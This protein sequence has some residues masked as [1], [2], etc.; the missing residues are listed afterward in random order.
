M[1]RLQ[2]ALSQLGSTGT[3]RR[4]GGAGIHGKAMAAGGGCGHR[5]STR[6]HPGQLE[7]PTQEGITEL[8]GIELGVVWHQT[9]VLMLS[10]SWTLHKELYSFI[11]ERGGQSLDEGMFP[12]PG[13]H[14]QATILQ[15]LNY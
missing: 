14:S 2:A 11:P 1:D 6:T 12:T 3:C 7:D 8:E 13:L 9:E 15:T 4:A 10:C 5:G